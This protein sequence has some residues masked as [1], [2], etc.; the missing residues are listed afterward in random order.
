MID[1]KVSGT[2]ITIYSV[3][4]IEHLNINIKLTFLKSVIKFLMT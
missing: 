2:F 4:I 3:F 1:A